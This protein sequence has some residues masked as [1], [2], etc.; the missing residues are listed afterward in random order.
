MP[1]FVKKQR[2]FAKEFH[3]INKYRPVM[4]IPPKVEQ[5]AQKRELK[6]SLSNMGTKL[7][8]GRRAGV[9]ERKGSRREA[10]QKILQKTNDDS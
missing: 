7:P 8:N 2:A 10:I 6:S 5:E 9:V 4:R 3:Q 1:E